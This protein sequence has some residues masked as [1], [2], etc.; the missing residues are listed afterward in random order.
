MFKSKS[1]ATRLTEIQQ[2]FYREA[3]TEW[4]VQSLSE[5]AHRIR[6][7]ILPFVLAFTIDGARNIFLS[8]NTC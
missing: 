5:F 8:N 2:I 1:D 3:S 6:I 7:A 4:F